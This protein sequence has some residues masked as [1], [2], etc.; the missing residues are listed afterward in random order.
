VAIAAEDR[1]DG[2]ILMDTSHGRLADIP[3]ERIELGKQVV[4]E[5]RMQAFIDVSD[6]LEGPGPLDTPAYAR[7]VAENPGYKEYADWRTRRSSPHMWVGLVDELVGGEDRL[8]ILSTLQVPTL[9]IVGEQDKPFLPHAQRMAGA[10]RDAHL[11]VL[12]DAGHS[13]QFENPSAWFAAVSDWLTAR[14]S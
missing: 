4:R 5:G 7:M 11:V 6:S 9:V 2:L 10:I 3:R 12:A 13:P 14:A 1:L 8:S